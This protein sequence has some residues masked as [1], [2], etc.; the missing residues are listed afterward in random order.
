[1]VDPVKNRLYT[2]FVFVCEKVATPNPSAAKRSNIF[3]ISGFYLKHSGTALVIFQ[4]D[5]ET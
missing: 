3:F 2:A 5:A 4:A 1:M